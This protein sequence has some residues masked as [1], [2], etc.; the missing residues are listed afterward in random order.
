VK[1]IR[2]R[3]TY[4]NVM[5]SIAVFLVLGGATAV[6]AKKIGSNEIKANSIKTGK[7]VKEAITTSKLKKNAVTTPKIKDDAVTGAKVNESTLGEVPSAATAK[8]ATSAGNASSVNGQTIHKILF[9]SGNNAPTTTLLDSGGLVIKATCTAGSITAIAE[10]TKQNSS[11][12]INAFDSAAAPTPS[13]VD[14]ESGQ[15]DVGDTIDLLAGGTGNN[16][17]SFLE[18]DAVDGTVA[19][20]ILNADLNGELEGCRLTGHVTVG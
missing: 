3:L 11:I 5:S 14:Q 12:Y 9:R 4:A 2:K 13:H 7:I 20:G 15:F 8:N 6:A 10:S 16:D 17:M 19:T 18:F 1:Q